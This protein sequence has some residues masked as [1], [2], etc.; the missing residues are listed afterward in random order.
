MS[1]RQ[2]QLAGTAPRNTSIQ[3]VSVL[4]RSVPDLAMPTIDTIISG[5]NTSK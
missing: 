5:L 4:R 1:L 2:P 3:E